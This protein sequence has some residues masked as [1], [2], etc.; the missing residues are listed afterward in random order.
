MADDRFDGKVAFVTGAANKQSMGRAVALRLAAAGADVAILDKYPNPRSLFPGDEEWGGLA[1][2]LEEIKHLGRN[3]L[4]LTTDI[5]S[6]TECVD[7]VE[8]VI[9]K[10]GRIDLFVHCAATRGPVG[11]PVVD[12]SEEDWRKLIEVNL[13]GTF[14]ITKP[15]ARHM[16]ER[17]GPGKM[18]LISSVASKIGVAGNS[19]Y[20][21]SKWGVLGFVQSLALE[22]AK[23]QINVN[24]ICPGHINT[25]LRD[26]WI[27]ENA[28]LEGMSIAEFREKAYAK[29]AETVPLGRAGTA[30]DIA[31]VVMFLLSKQADYMTGQGINVSGGHYMN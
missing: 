11:V 8:K 5:G 10:F 16:V 30:Q 26:L 7:A 29:M 24:S 17:G 19:G 23:Y 13:T 4:A 28:K 15:V 25:N 21:S 20:V 9:E 18:V 31:D 22:L 27:E 12:L 6:S 3:A 14:L 1:E 2:E